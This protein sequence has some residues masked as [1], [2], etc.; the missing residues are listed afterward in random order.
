VSVS[1]P[2]WRAAAPA[3]RP[4]GL[5]GLRG[6][7]GLPTSLRIGGG[8]LL[9]WVLL[10]L[11]APLVLP[12]G[13]EA[14]IY[15]KKLLP[16]SAEFPFGTDPTGRD[17]LARVI[18]SF[19]YDM[20]IA[21]GGVAL[22]IAGGVL[23]GTVAASAR[24]IVDDAIMRVLDVVSAFPSFV[25][26]LTLAAALGANVVNLVVAIGVVY[27]PYYARL[28]RAQMMAERGKQYCEAARC[29]GLSQRR[30]VLAHLLPNSLSPVV[31]QAAMHVA[32]AMMIAS[33]IS[34]LGFGVRPPTPEWGLMI[35]EGAS[36]IVSGQWWVAVFPGVAIIS[37]VTSFILLDD[38]LR[39]KLRLL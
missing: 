8:V 15:G 36:Y 9:F 35:S 18:Y 29:M 7:R 12:Y 31:T 14:V 30:I 16:P 33:G 5:R 38:G 1:T 26:A 32:T 21:L 19:R 20:A 24:A 25:L 4:L 34:Y 11:V 13:P 2:A 6:L 17:V 3:L 10:S 39:Q 22:A 27:V 28:V 23:C 37:V